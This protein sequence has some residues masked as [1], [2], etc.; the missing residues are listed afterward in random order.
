MIWAD[1]VFVTVVAYFKRFA[2]LPVHVAMVTLKRITVY[3]LRVF[4]FAYSFYVA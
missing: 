1:F 2:R 3:V 4:G